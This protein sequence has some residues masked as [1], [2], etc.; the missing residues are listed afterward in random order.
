M[1]LFLINFKRETQ[2]VIQKLKLRFITKA[3]NEQSFF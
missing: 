1:F 3:K 2:K